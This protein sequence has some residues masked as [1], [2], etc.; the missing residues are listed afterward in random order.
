MLAQQTQ[1]IVCLLGSPWKG[2]WSFP[3]KKAQKIDVHSMSSV[4]ASQ[5]EPL[6]QSGAVCLLQI[7][8]WEMAGPA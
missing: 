1:H 2:P 8:I 5:Q 7:S 4:L 3:C 6:Y